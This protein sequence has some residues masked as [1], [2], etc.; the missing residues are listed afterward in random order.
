MNCG[1]RCR[2]STAELKGRLTVRV[3][4]PQTNTGWG[5]EEARPVPSA[6]VIKILI[7]WEAVRSG[8]DL[9]ERVDLPAAGLVGGSGVLRQMAPGMRPTWQDLLTLMLVVS[10]N[11]A[12]NLLIDRLGFQ[13]VN[14]A[15][16]QLGLTD[17]LM[18]RRMMDLDA[19]QRGLDNYMSA[20]D[21]ARLLSFLVKQAKAGH[22]GASLILHILESQQFNHKLPLLVPDIPCAHKT[23]ELPGLEH[24]AGVFWLPVGGQRY[25]VVVSVFTSHLQQ[26]ADGCLAIARV[27]RAAVDSFGR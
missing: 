22:A 7:A 13:A 3:E 2:R 17:T 25:P 6:S 12:T 15:A 18:E 4:D 11:S 23:G 1:H 5:Y 21:A 26:K 16:A 20:L 27:G 24:D 14:T 9:N 10:D 19:R 8:L